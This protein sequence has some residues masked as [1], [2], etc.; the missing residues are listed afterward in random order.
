MEK[1]VKPS[2]AFLFS[3]ILREIGDTGQQMTA[4]GA[5]EGSA[6]NISVFVRSV[7]GVDEHFW[8]H[9]V[10][11]LPVACPALQG[12]WLVVTGA[13]R[14]MRDLSQDPEATLIILEILDGGRQATLF[15]ASNAK[16]TSELNSH[17]AIHD[18]QVG[19]HNLSYSAIVHAQP[20]FLTYISHLPEYAD[21]TSLNRHL[22]RWEPET[23]ITFPE[24][25]GM[26]PFHVPG[27]PEQMA[28]TMA[29]LQVFRAVVWRR[30]GI[31]TRSD[32]S[33]RK[34]GDLV[35]YAE[36]AAHFEY[37]N[38]QLGRPTEGLSDDELHAICKMY[39]INQKFF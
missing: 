39:G 29:G 7:E 30:H 34:A 5:D 21:T 28:D 8:D 12:G 22:L 11:D 25:I 15:S 24:G 23:I 37:L 2:K 36:T 14:R 9:G 27:S 4:L 33:V 19:R 3:K 31:V 26:I 13:G 10:I 32:E 18:D 6:G 16:P 1:I 35:E 17:L 38:L 20:R